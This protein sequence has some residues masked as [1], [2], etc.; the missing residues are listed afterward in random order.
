MKILYIYL[1]F[2]LV[3]II[4]YHSFPTLN[5]LFNFN[6]EYSMKKHKKVKRICYVLSIIPIVNVLTMILYLSEDFYR[7]FNIGGNKNGRIKKWKSN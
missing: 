1:Y 2:I 5:R 4:Y 7:C 3:N 6:P